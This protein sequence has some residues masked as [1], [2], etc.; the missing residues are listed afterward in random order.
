[1]STLRRLV[2]SHPLES[3]WIG[4]V[5]FSAIFAPYITSYDPYLVDTTQRLQGISLKHPF[6]T[7]E[8]G[9]DLLTRL[10]Y[11]SRIVVYVIF[12]SAF[13]SLLGGTVIGL[14]AGYF[15]KVVDLILSRVIDAMQAFPA[16]L[17]GVMLAAAMGP[18]LQT[19][20][21]SIGL[22]GTPVLARVVRG[23]VLEIKE[24]EYTQASRA[25]G[26][27]SIHI[28]AKTILPN[29]LSPI[30][31]QTS[32]IAP[33][34]IIN[35]AGLSFLGLGAQPPQP[36]WGAM[37]AYARPYI[38]QQPTYLI[39]VVIILSL[40]IISLNLLGDGLRDILIKK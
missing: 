34:A 21:L 31:I 14:I 25:I 18:S 29:V 1:M 23:S 40:T 2:K 38:Y 35:V 20:I 30:I 8:F 15:G 4:L 28:I 6:G 11:G 5:L 10:I 26:A 36:S 27:S 16:I 33:R 17:I 19:A 24:M 9:R 3:L 13:L 22:F 39:V 7:D 32:S 37:I 12:L